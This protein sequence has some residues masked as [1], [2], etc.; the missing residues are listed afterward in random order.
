MASI[1]DLLEQIEGE[2]NVVGAY[3]DD[4]DVKALAE[5]SLM[6]SPLSET[7]KSPNSCPSRTPSRSG[8]RSA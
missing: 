4:D 8:T 1:S 5:N 3:G 6:E 7:P 2:L